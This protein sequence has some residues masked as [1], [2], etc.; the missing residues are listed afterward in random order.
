[1]ET[2]KRIA[3]TFTFEIEGDVPEEVENDLIIDVEQMTDDPSF[4]WIHE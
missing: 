4:E 2:K 3:F 1:M